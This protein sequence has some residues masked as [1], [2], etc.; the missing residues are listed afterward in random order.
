ML[1]KDLGEERYTLFVTLSSIEC[2][3][4]GELVGLLEQQ[5]DL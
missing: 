3:D 2:C 4:V 1:K 5:E